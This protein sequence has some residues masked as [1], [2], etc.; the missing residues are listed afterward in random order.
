MQIDKLF[1]ESEN[2]P[3]IVVIDRVLPEIDSGKFAIKRYID[4]EIK[5]TAHLLVHGHDLPKGRLWYRHETE[6]NYTKV[7]LV[8]KG[9]DEWEAS[10]KPKKLGRYLCKI[11]AAKDSFTTWT[12]DLKKR[13][14]AQQDI[15]VDL[16]IGESIIKHTW[17][18]T[19]QGKHKDILGEALRTIGTWSSEKSQTPKT[20]LNFFSSP[21]LEAAM[22]EF[23]ENPVWYDHELPIQVEPLLARYSSWY[24][25]FPR[26]T[27]S[28][29]IPHGTFKM[30]QDRLN[31]IKDMGFNVVYFPPIHPVGREFRKGKNNSTKAEAGDVGSPWAIG[32]KEGG[33][34]DIL[35]ALGTLKDFKG[36]IEKARSLKMEIAMDIAFQCAPD[37]PYVKAHPEWFKHRPD[38]TIQYA[39]NPPKKYQDIYPFDFECKEWK[40]LWQELLSVV[41]YWVNQG[42]RVFRVDNPHTKPFHFWEWLI[43]EVRLKNPEVIFLAEAFTRPKMMAY[44]AKAG[45][46]QSYTY[47][48][49]RNVKWE[50]TQ[51]MTEL[52]QTELKDYFGAN[53]W[54][55]TPDILHEH[56]QEDNPGVYKQR[57]ILAATLMSNYGIYGPAFELMS[58]QPKEKGSEE[59][60]HSEKYEVKNW[61]LDDP[62]SLAPFIRQINQIRENHPSLQQNRTFRF[63]PVD[64]E[65]IIAYSK[66]HGDEKIVVVVNLDSRRSQSG[67]V[68]L[69]LID[70]KIAESEN[71]EMEDLLTGVFYTW[72]GWRNFV[73]LRPNQPAHIF[74]LKTH[75]NKLVASGAN[76]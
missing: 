38:G 65:S 68:E 3:S 72:R 26:S 1:N 23:F 24:E 71:Y 7:D 31:Y 9:N 48:T 52:T 22:N 2:P 60:L 45:F 74:K 46:S 47:F 35:P 17:R 56:L 57:L 43:R 37:H 49:W 62:R 32:A 13:I 5:I 36:L 28:K 29:D 33:H 34:K 73:E 51:Y 44:L 6:K 64:N 21:V 15:K 75:K 53:F 16:Q 12:T 11:E 27:V 41:T 8:S 40:S 10:F 55:N 14:N 50:L 54:P 30:A 59:Y 18:H 20:I 76:A 58:Y 66:T 63:H 69:P 61:N 39:E 25:F 4:E 42:V 19:P 67:L 70:W